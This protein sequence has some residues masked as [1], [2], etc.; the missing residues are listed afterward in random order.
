MLRRFTLS[1][2]LL[3]GLAALAAPDVPTLTL[4]WAVPGG[5][6]ALALD[7]ISACFLLPA[8]VITAAGTLYGL[9]YWS[10]R[11]QPATAGA[12]RFW[13]GMMGASL[14]LVMTA[15]NGLLFL[16]AWEVMA[17][18]GF[19]LIVTEANKATVRRAGFVYLAAT[20]VGTL[21]LFALFALLS[22]RV[23]SFA[24]PAAGTLGRKFLNVFRKVIDGIAAGRPGRHGKI[25]SIGFYSGHAD[26]HFHQVGR[27]A[28]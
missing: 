28:S 26:F 1:C 24:F 10:R 17:L 9:G 12:T 14:A 23:G 21:A 8:F 2:P 7:G 4:P 5:R 22:H 13:Y 15:R 27:R 20:H 16:A 18:V 6:F 11:E 25:Q 19:F 3:V